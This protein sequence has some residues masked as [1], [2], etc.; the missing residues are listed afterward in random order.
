MTVEIEE[1]HRVGSTRAVP[2]LLEGLGLVGFFWLDGWRRV[3]EFEGWMQVA[4]PSP[5]E[6]SASDPYVFV[7][8]FV[9]PGRVPEMLALSG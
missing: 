7:F 1:R 8:Y 4:S 3:G 5:A 9:P 2:A 6:F